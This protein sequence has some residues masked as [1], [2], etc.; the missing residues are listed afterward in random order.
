MF[1][2]IQKH[3]FVLILFLSLF[4]LPSMCSAKIFS[5][6]P[7]RFII[8]NVKPG[9]VLTKS[10][11]VL[12]GFDS[13]YA[14]E[15][16]KD[17][18]IFRWFK[19]T[20]TR[21]LPGGKLEIFFEI[22]LPNEVQFGNYESTFNIVAVNVSE[23]TQNASTKNNLGYQIPVQII[24]GNKDVVEYKM[25]WM[26]A[27][28]AYSKQPFGW[29]FA[30]GGIS[31]IYELSNLGNVASAPD[32]IKFE[33]FKN[34]GGAK[35]EEFISKKNKSIT[36]YKTERVFSEIPTKLDEG[37]YYMTVSVFQKGQYRPNQVLNTTVHISKKNLGFLEK[38]MR[39][40]F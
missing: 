40:Y 28:F 36:A 8:E 20:D 22:S 21:S 33:L 7:S 10:I 15:V 26:E 4:L 9:N 17:D 6:T 3:V 24:V 27:P 30:K 34:E 39:I 11:V 25:N 2:F 23:L 18:F 1:T 38:L 37:D 32:V 19:Q 35:L 12:G 31:V 29:F 16:K 5:V 13:S 14:I